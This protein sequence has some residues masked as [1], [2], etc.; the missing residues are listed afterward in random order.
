LFQLE[1]PAFETLDKLANC[2]ALESLALEGDGKPDY[3][4][5]DE[6]PEVVQGL[7]RWLQ[8]RASLRK[9]ELCSFPWGFKLLTQIL[10]APSLCLTCLDD[11]D[12]ELYTSLSHQTRLRELTLRTGVD[13]FFIER[14][15]DHLEFFDAICC[16]PE[17]RELATDELFTF[18]DVENISKALPKLES[19]TLVPVFADWGVGDDL[20]VLF[21]SLSDL[22]RLTISAF[23]NISA[24][25]LLTFLENMKQDGNRCHEGL[26]IKMTHQDDRFRLSKEEEALVRSVLS[27]HFKGQLTIT[28]REF[29][30]DVGRWVAVNDDGGEENTDT[31]FTGSDFLHMLS[32]V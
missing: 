1:R 17:L 29:P 32:G 25:G 6:C 19:I 26:Q 12:G 30:D 24:A 4:T 21:S 7:V 9:L 22:K 20:L 5:E 8:N 27:T 14:D 13:D 3:P 10:N 15:Q 16:C 2:L 31:E 28:Y 11:F 23:S 18:E